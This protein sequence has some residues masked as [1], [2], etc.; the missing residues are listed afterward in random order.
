MTQRMLRVLTVLLIAAVAGLAAAQLL[1][2]VVTTD[3][4]LSVGVPAGWSGDAAGTLKVDATSDDGWLISVMVGADANYSFS[5]DAYAPPADIM[6]HFAAFMEMTGATAGPD[7]PAIIDIGIIAGIHQTFVTHTGVPFEAVAYTMP[8]GMSALALVGNQGSQQAI[9][10]AM[11]ETFF[12][13]LSSATFEAPAASSDEADATDTDEIYLPDGATLISELPAGTL[14][15]NGNVEATYAEG[16]TIY[17][18]N[19][20]YIT[21][22]ASL[23]YG[24]DIFNY[25][26]LMTITVEDSLDLPLET[27]RESVLPFSAQ[28]FIG[29][30]TFDPARDIITETLPDGRQI[31]SLDTT[32]SE[33]IAGN[34]YI[35]PLDARY[36]VWTMATTLNPE[37]ADDRIA[38]VR[39]LMQSMTLVLPEGAVEYE[40]FQLLLQNATCERVLTTSDVNQTAPYAI[41]DCPAGCADSSYSIWGSDIYTL[42]SSI[43]AAA[44]HAGVISNA[45]GGTLMTIWQPGQEAYLS[46]ERNGISTIDYGAWSDS[47]VVAPFTLADDE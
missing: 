41:F 47:F 16:W 4:G 37:V 31:Y 42:D 44:I 34:I 32:D 10:D 8:D 45:D 33:A 11:R 35:V 15:F 13:V 2:T 39:A 6:Q 9:S 1:T 36:W 38:D 28:V 7:E 30:E 29:R 3:G 25:D 43:C 17:A 12:A 40:G 27:F 24:S 5:G 14:R 20:P 46:T 18:D 21:T 22:H 19:S 26:A 23:L